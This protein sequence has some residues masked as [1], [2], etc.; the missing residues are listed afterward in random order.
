MLNILDHYLDGGEGLEVFRRRWLFR[1]VAT[2]TVAT[3]L[4]YI[5]TY[6]EDFQRT[7]SLSSYSRSCILKVDI[8]VKNGSSSRS[9]ISLTTVE[10]TVGFL[11]SFLS[12]AERP[13]VI[14]SNDG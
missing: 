1:D 4:R 8:R 10:K 13:F 6:F 5:L 11:N 2:G 12:Q 14:L 7:R 9:V 3:A